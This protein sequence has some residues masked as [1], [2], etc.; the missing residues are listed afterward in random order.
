MEKVIGRVLDDE[1]ENWLVE[2]PTCQKEYEYEGHFDPSQ[3]TECV[4]GCLFNTKRI[5]F[6]D[7]SYIEY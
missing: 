1:G 5:E 7:G 2:C 3:V 4:C 6:D